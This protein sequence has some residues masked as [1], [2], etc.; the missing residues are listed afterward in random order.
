MF[1]SEIL[2]NGAFAIDCFASSIDA[3][4]FSLISLLPP[5]SLIYSRDYYMNSK[6][7]DALQ[8]K[9]I[10]LEVEISLY[11]CCAMKHQR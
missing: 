4:S 7:T 11:Q 2:Q 9:R 1:L 8:K 5:A 10:L 6:I 3:T